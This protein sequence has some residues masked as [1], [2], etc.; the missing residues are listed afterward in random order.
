MPATIV[1]GRLAALDE[2]PFRVALGSSLA[3]MLGV[4]IGDEVRL[5]LPRFSATPLGLFPR[6][7]SLTVVAIFSVGADQDTNH[8]YV[9][10]ETAQRLLGGAPVT[11]LRLRTDDLFAAPETL[12]RLA[13]GLAPGTVVR[14]WSQTQGSLFRAVRMEKLTV[15]LLL[16]SVVAVAA[17]NIVATL[18]MSVAEKRSDIAVLRTLGADPAGILR[19]FVVHGFALAAV[20]VALGAVAGVALALSIDRIAA[21]LERLLRAQLFDPA[22][23]FITGLPSALAWS[24]VVAVVLASLLLGLLATLYPAWRAAQVPPVDALRHG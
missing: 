3:R 6:G 5:T 15:S 12:R 22:V 11:G 23:Y 8:A 9:S 18:V 2:G 13:A 19:V 14:D 4:G 21:A 1:A 7:R 24:D 10:L 16:L 20:G 17:F